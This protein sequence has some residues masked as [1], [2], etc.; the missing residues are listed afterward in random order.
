MSTVRHLALIPARSGSLRVKG[1][2]IRVLAG[3]PMIAYSIASALQSGLYED[4]VV[5]TNSKLVADIARHYGASVPFLRPEEFATATSPDI[6]FLRHALDT[7]GKEYD[8]FSLLRP[9]SPLRQAETIL[10]AWDRLRSLPEADSVR[11]VSLCKEHPGKM[12]IV[13]GEAM[14][15]LLDQDHLEVAWH[16]RQ[17]QDCPTVYVQ[18]SSLEIA[19]AE[20]VARYGTREGKVVA[21]FF[22]DEFES[23]AIDYPEDLERLE[24]WVTKGRCKLPAIERPAYVFPDE[25]A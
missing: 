11:A 5:S 4:V 23:F 15:P 25:A 13:E 12:W 21:P 10:H 7:L 2:N 17:Y 14:R 16:A 24:A 8:Y 22:S 9:T 20:V 19:K 3:H 18:N 1:K 6:E